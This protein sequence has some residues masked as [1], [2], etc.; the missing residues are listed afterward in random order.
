[1]YKLKL[2]QVVFKEGGPKTKPW[3]ALEFIF[4]GQLMVNHKFFAPDSYK[5]RRAVSSQ[6]RHVF[7]VMGESYDDIPYC[8][9]F[10]MF[11][12]EVIQRM[13]KHYGTEVYALLIEQKDYI[14]LA[15][16]VPFL[17]HLPDL[18]YTGID[19]L[20]AIKGTKPK[21]KGKSLRDTSAEDVVAARLSGKI[22]Y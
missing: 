7:D 21:E 15:S 11:A 14:T 22:A 17:S 1:M 3:Q 20:Y 18:E 9:D 12:L 8:A 19:M 6:I 16:N 2:A 13:E 10:Y 4:T 5:D